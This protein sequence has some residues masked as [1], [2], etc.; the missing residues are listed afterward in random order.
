MK[1]QM[2]NSMSFEKVIKLLGRCL[3]VHHMT[4]PL[5]KYIVPVEPVFTKQGNLFVLHFFIFQKN[6]AQTVGNRDRTNTA[7]GFWDL[8]YSRLVAHLDD[9]TPDIKE[10]IFKINIVPFQPDDLTASRPGEQCGA[11]QCLNVVRFFYKS[12][13]DLID[14][15]VAECFNFGMYDFGNL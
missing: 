10:M 9:G 4:V 7:D 15:I 8:F 11:D 13:Q 5:R 2:A 6:F 12:R 3:R 14:L 1:F